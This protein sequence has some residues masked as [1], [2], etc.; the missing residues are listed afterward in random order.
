MITVKKLF[1]LAPKHRYRKARQALT[2][3]ETMLRSRY[4]PET[5]VVPSSSTGTHLDQETEEASLPEVLVWLEA[6][7][8]ACGT[9]EEASAKVHALADACLALLKRISE[10]CALETNTNSTLLLR[11]L[12]ESGLGLELVRAVNTLGH[13]LEADF[14]SAPADWDFFAPLG[15]FSR[16]RSYFKGVKVFLED[17]RSPFNVGSIF[18]TSDAC[19]FEEVLLSG[20]S[21]G[22]LHPRSLRTAM[23]AADVVP[24]RSMSLAELAAT[25]SPILGLELGAE[26]IDAFAFPE[27]G[28]VVL[29]SEE[30]GISP[31][32]RSL[33]TSVVSI[34]MLGAK[35]SL[36]VGVAFGI[37]AN[38]WRAWLMSQGINPVQEALRKNE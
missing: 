3:M 36:N 4:V 25:E 9:D 8:L 23:G 26:S 38:A 29:G 6:F 32:A 16:P 5:L 17:I 7:C 19:G 33:C 31:E 15:G 14:G 35:G 1:T 21:A 27:R 12:T 10:V 28:I 18:R 11:V 30:L 37:L 34:P 22:P 13:T 24:W 2:L 20:L